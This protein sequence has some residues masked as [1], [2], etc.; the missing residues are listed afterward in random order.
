VKLFSFIGL[1]ALS[2]N[3]HAA[4]TAESLYDIV[5]ALSGV[6]AFEVKDDPQVI[7]HRYSDSKE[8]YQ[9]SEFIKELY[10]EMG[11]RAEIQDYDPM[12]V[13]PL[14]AKDTEV[15]YRNYLGNM[16]ATLQEDFDGFCAA[17][18][19]AEKTERVK[20]SLA[21]SGLSQETLCKEEPGAAR[22][23][24]YVKAVV[25]HAI[26]ASKKFLTDRKLEKWPNVV[27]IV[28][29]RREEDS[30]MSE[31][32]LCVFTAHLDSVA[33]EGGSRG[34][35]VSP[36][37]AAPGADDNATG[38]AA[39]VSMARE[40]SAWIRTTNQTGIPCDL[41]FVHVSGE[42]E[43][44]L[45]SLSFIHK[46]NKRPILWAMNFDMIGYNSA[47][48][49]KWNIGYDANLDK[50]L[51]KIFKGE[52]EE[53]TP[54]YDAV[55]VERKAYAYSSDQFSYWGAGIPAFSISELT[56]ID[57]ECKTPYANTN[58]NIHTPGDTVDLLDFDYAAAIVNESIEGAKR[59]LLIYKPN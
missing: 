24:L 1:L 33:R 4:V 2:L 53:G 7:Q 9:A 52:P 50:G 36:H 59:L 3:A 15:L 6:A 22:F 21:R 25:D 5:E 30:A 51:L 42:E 11:I 56:C 29:T 37:E 34:R 12:D 35:I 58:P 55:V 40:L 20:K 16:K 19:D 28:E 45:G 8:I 23:E 38:T 31:R 27:A 10:G 49:N 13:F 18:L 32:P 48:L 43:G 14:Y 41:A 39:L 46:Q 26:G 17:T 47:K 54:T 44:L 57:A